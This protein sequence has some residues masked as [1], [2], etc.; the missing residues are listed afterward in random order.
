M[1]TVDVIN[2]DVEV[3]RQLLFWGLDEGFLTANPLAQPATPRPG[4]RLHVRGTRAVHRACADKLHCDSHFVHCALLL[5]RNRRAVR[6]HH[7]GNT[8]APVFG[9]EPS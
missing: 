1:E 6:D 9:R 2:R 7:G 5:A 4:P 3:L 8:A